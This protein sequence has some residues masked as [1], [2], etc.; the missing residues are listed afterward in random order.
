MNSHQ[1]ISQVLRGHSLPPLQ[2]EEDE[3]V[4]ET[5]LLVKVVEVDGNV[6]WRDALGRDS[7]GASASLIYVVEQCYEELLSRMAAEWRSE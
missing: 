3:Q 6:S 2:L 7:L 5:Y 1:Q 4:A